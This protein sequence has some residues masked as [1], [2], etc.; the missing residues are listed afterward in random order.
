MTA[1]LPA[2]PPAPCRAGAVLTAP[3]QFEPSPDREP[4]ITEVSDFALHYAGLAHFFARFAPPPAPL[5]SKE[6][7]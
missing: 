5:V 1:T 6:G 2:D 7:A 4:V 3:T